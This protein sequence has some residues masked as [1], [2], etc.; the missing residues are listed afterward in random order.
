[1]LNAQQA[2]GSPLVATVK[3]RNPD[4]TRL[5]ILDAAETLF[6]EEGFEATSLGAIGAAAGVSRGTPSYFFGS[7]RDLYV[8]VLERVFAEREAVTEEAFRPLVAWSETPS[9]ASL[10][11][12]LVA[13]VDGYLSFLQE[14][15]AFVRLLQRE[16][17]AGGRHLPSV[18]RKSSAMNAAFAQ[19]KATA[20]QHGLGRFEVD[21]AVLLFV[22]LTF[23]P[24]TQRATF[25]AALRRDLEDSRT[26]RQHVSL[27]A[28]QLMALLRGPR[29]EEL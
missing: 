7:K 6:A 8:A 10:K 24:L 14:R 2:S 19:V 22:S 28:D 11:P 26:R 29:G 21:D 20:R 17:L 16:D 3:Q 27:V 23:A 4:Q 9:L 5:A 25:L 12:A 13:A 15:R 18:R 1:M